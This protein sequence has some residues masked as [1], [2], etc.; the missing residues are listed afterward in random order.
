MLQAL[1]AIG[2]GNHTG[3]EIHTR[4]SLP[5]SA[6]PGCQRFSKVESRSRGDLVGRRKRPS[7]CSRD[8]IGRKQTELHGLWTREE[9]DLLRANCGRPLLELARIFGR[10]PNAIRIRLQVLGPTPAPIQAEEPPILEPEHANL[11]LQ[12]KEMPETIRPARP[13]RQP[14]PTPM[15]PNLS[16]NTQRL[17]LA[18][19]VA[20]ALVIGFLLGRAT[21]PDDRVILKELEGGTTTRPDSIAPAGVSL[22]NSSPLESSAS[23]DPIDIVSW[24][25]RGYPEKR[26]SDTNWFHHQLTVMGADV[27]CIQEIANLERIATLRTRHGSLSHCMF[28]DS[29]RGMDNAILAD[30]RVGLEDMS[31][32]GGFQHP[33]QVAYA[34]CQGFDAVIVC[35]HL[36]WG[37]EAIRK[38]ELKTLQ[39]C[40]DG[41]LQRDPDLILIGDF[42]LMGDSIAAFARDVG[43]ITMTGDRYDHV[44]IS[45]DLAN[46]E[47]VSARI[48]R[49]TGTDSGIAERVSD[50]VP[51][52]ATF[53]IDDGYQDRAN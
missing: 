40:I 41:W 19:L 5:V 21:A 8:Q 9:D 15:Q 47:A 10:T 31:D 48:V 2:T 36:T 32:P 34:F 42:N 27:L 46:E 44:L 35:L 7:T 37:D 39:Q 3:R 13:G 20:L 26:E 24:N 14:P 16:S 22:A 29:R 18:L 38:L 11:T 33:P 49:F 52:V 1:S 23:A 30:N 6:F 17:G 51:L 50:H 43:M 12:L 25:V 28:A 53:R 45:P 4:F